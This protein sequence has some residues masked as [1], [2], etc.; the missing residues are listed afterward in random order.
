MAPIPAPLTPPLVLIVD[1]E[2]VLLSCL[3]LVLLDA[4]YRVLT[5]QDGA[6]ALRVLAHERPD[7]IVLDL[8]MPLMD[9]F[10]FAREYAELP[11]GQSPIV[12]LTA[13][14]SGTTAAEQ[15]GAAALV[16]KPFDI[17][18]VLRA[19]EAC[20]IRRV[21]TRDAGCGGGATGS[22]VRATA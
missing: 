18:T 3:E 6:A 1:D 5:A 22:S 17:D 4:G 19:L 8:Q 21:N 10:T 2:A 15:I 13:S 16:E 9:G 7:V 14:D 12:L 11:I 20:L